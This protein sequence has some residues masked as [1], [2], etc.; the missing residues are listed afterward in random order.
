[1]S[2]AIKERMVGC[3][4]ESRKSE[5]LGRRRTLERQQRPLGSLVGSVCRRCWSRQKM[6]QLNP[7]RAY[8]ENVG[9]LLDSLMR[10]A[11]MGNVFRRSNR[12]GF[13]SVCV[14][15]TQGRVEA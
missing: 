7:S 6:P 9:N 1:M 2:R 14:R 13:R 4:H 8:P 10:R 3:L 5:R 12:G 15:V 11:A